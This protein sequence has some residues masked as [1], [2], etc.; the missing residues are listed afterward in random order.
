MS[1][2]DTASQV[3]LRDSSSLSSFEGTTVMCW[4]DVSIHGPD[5]R[6]GRLGRGKH[7]QHQAPHTGAQGPDGYISA[8]VSTSSSE[9]WCL[10]S[11]TQHCIQMTPSPADVWRACHVVHATG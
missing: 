2:Q 4:A 1:A 8:E 10:L 9:P 7:P 5:P 6:D 11:K 3:A